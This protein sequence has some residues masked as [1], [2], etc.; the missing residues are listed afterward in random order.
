MRIKKKE[1]TL[2]EIQKFQQEFDKKY[3]S[4]YWNDKG[5]VRDKID[6]LKDMTI[7]LTGELGEFANIIK[8]AN[9]DKNQ[10]RQELSKDRLNKLREELIDCFIY[11]VILSNILEMDIEEELL[12]KVKFNEKRF[13]KY[14]K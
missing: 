9:R 13:Q 12:K 6:F 4:K 1:M 2:K 5:I 8:K 7:A 14:L 10:L 3:F 11:L